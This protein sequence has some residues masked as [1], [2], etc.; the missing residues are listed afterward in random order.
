MA[1]PIEIV[2]LNCALAGVVAAIKSS[3]T[4]VIHT[5]L[6]SN[7]LSFM[8]LLIQLLRATGAW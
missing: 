2:T 3:A 8:V 4:V 6:L 5:N 7:L 1:S